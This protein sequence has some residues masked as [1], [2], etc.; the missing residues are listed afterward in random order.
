MTAP[1]CP[2]RL[3]GRAVRPAMYPNTGRDALGDHHHG[4]EPRLDGFKR[5]ILREPGRDKNARGGRPGS[6]HGLGRGVKHRHA[7][8]LRSAFAR[9]DPGDDP[10]AELKHPGGM[11][12]A[13]IARDALHEYP[14]VLADEDAHAPCATSATTRRAASCGST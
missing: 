7:V 4:I 2:I 13:L 14:R 10:R 12:L 9:R 5:G 6:L 1:A 11:E 8:H 3:P